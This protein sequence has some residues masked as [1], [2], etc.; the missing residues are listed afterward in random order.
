MRLTWTVVYD[1]YGQTPRLLTFLP[2]HK[3]VQRDMDHLSILRK[4]HNAHYMNGVMFR[5]PDEHEVA[6]KL[7]VLVRNI[8]SSGGR[9][10]Q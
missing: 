7:V 3:L 1:I 6:S 2:D 5:G 9:L 8:Q 4:Y 10:T